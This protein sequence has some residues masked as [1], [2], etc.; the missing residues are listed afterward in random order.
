MDR[1]SFIL[2]L[3][4]GA[5]AASVGAVA[6]AQAAPT[7]LAPL[8]PESRPVDLATASAIDETDAEFTRHRRGHRMM[9]RR[10][11]NMRRMRRMDRRARPNTQR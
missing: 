5:A 1:R 3:I 10:R 9:H 7:V 11:M 8:P 4:G 6:M 2:S